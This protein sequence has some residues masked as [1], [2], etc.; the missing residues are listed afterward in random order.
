MEIDSSQELNKA[1]RA[2]GKKK[3][4]SI[5]FATWPNLRD[6]TTRFA[7]YITNIVTDVDSGQPLLTM[8]V[9]EAFGAINTNWTDFNNER[10]FLAGLL[11]HSPKLFKVRVGINSSDEFIPWDPMTESMTSFVARHSGDIEVIDEPFCKIGDEHAR[12]LFAVRLMS[13][14]DIERIGVDN[15][16]R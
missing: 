8:C 11:R 2:A 9:T 12:L 1:I 15:V 5:W 4:A 10:A 14:A 3:E 16:V 6:I 7:E 13:A